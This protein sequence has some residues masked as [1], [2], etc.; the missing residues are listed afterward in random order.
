MFR[1]IIKI[2][3]EKCNGCGLCVP[4]CVEGA[5]KIIDGKVK[6]VSEVYCDGLGACI[7]DCPQGA[8]SIEKREAGEF[9][10]NAVKEYLINEKKREKIEHHV[11]NSCPGSALRTLQTNTTVREYSEEIQESQLGHWPVQLMLIPPQAP[12]LKGADIIVC[13]D[14]VP[15]TVPDFHQRYLKDRAVIVGCPKLDNLSYYREKLV[16]IFREASPKSIT[17]LRMEVPCCGGIAGAVIE[18]RDKALPDMKVD[19]HTIG[20]QG[21]ILRDTA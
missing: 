2:D 19:V 10:E 12:F 8:I 7:G 9:D 18:A 4:A 3:E 5:L 14:C 6:L 15:F 13:A 17:V 16:D 21:D 11:S 20:I 1:E